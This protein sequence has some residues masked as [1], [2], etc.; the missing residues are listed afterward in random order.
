MTNIVVLGPHALFLES[1]SRVSISIQKINIHLLYLCSLL[2]CAYVSCSCLDQCVWIDKY[3]VTSFWC[4]CQEQLC[5][6]WEFLAKNPS[7]LWT[8][9]DPVYSYFFWR[10]RFDSKH[11]NHVHFVILCVSIVVIHRTTFYIPIAEHTNN[12]ACCLLIRCHLS[13]N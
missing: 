2:S 4:C 6:S 13:I 5:S 10:F 8:S 9:L 12:P 7:E 1:N 11:E 3:F